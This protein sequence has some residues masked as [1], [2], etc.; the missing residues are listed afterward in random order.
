MTSAE[1]SGGPGSAALTSLSETAIAANSIS[2]GGDLSPDPESTLVTSIERRSSTDDYVKMAADRAKRL[3]LI[4]PGVKLDGRAKGHSDRFGS[5]KD[6]A[7]SRLAPVNWERLV[8]EDGLYCTKPCFISVER[9]GIS[10]VPSI[11]FDTF[12]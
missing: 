8:S 12:E 7:A 9:S 4:A 3:G 6:Q 11:L 5:V 2:G 1:L 10:N